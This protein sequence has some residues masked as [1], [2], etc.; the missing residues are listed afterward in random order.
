MFTKMTKEGISPDSFTYR[1]LI[2]GFCLIGEVDEAYKFLARSIE[3]E[4]IPSMATFGKLLNRLCVDDNTYDAVGIVRI[5][6]S[7][8][9]VPEVVN[10]IFNADK[11]RIAAPKILVE[12]LLKRGGFC[13]P[14]NNRH[15]RCQ[16]DEFGV[17]AG[18]WCCFHVL[19]G[20][21]VAKISVLAGANKNVKTEKGD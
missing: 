12:E 8:G 7:K 21:L 3:E 5:M 1:V 10:T 6:V 18:K 13:T 2:E 20:Y 19:L 15:A 11:R 4:L 16:T 14:W 9:V 17:S